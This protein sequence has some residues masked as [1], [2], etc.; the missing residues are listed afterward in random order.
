MD[1]LFGTLSIAAA[2]LV[3]W[4]WWLTDR[5]EARRLA[6]SE[7]AEERHLRAEAMKL[8]LELLRKLPARVDELEH[9]VKQLG[10]KK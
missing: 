9:T 8:D 6:A 10:W 5:A 2:A 1:G 3:A 4:R 7:A